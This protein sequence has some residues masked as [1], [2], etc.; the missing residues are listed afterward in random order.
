MPLRAADRWRDFTTL[1]HWRDYLAAFRDHQVCDRLRLATSRGRPLGDD[2]FVAK[3]E[4][5]LG[6][7]LRPGPNGRPPKWMKQG[8]PNEKKSNIPK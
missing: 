1:P 7:R 4:T 5:A 6:C 2:S 3:I 8:G